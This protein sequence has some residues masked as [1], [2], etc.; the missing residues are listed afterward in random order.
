VNQNYYAWID[1]ESTGL[2]ARKGHILEV[3]CII[4]DDKLNV[5]S[6]Y[7]QVIKLPWYLRLFPRLAMDAFV[8]NMHTQNG[9]LEETRDV[10]AVSLMEARINFYQFLK[11]YRKN[12]TSQ[13]GITTYT[14]LYFVGNSLGALDI[15]FLKEHMPEVLELAHYRTIDITGMRLGLEL[16]FDAPNSFYYDASSGTH[17]ALDDARA[18]INQFKFYKNQLTKK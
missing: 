11:P 6:M 2:N 9:L 4:T 13:G 16:A 7:S 10:F 5:L 12:K 8:L 18:C 15:P 1:L 14:N 17:R 3:A